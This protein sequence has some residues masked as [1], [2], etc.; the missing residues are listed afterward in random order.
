[1]PSEAVG[2]SGCEVE[3][4]DG[5]ISQVPKP[6]SKVGSGIIGYEMR[7]FGGTAA[8]ASGHWVAMLERVF[9]VELGTRPV[10]GRSRQGVGE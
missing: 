5:E 8:T 4:G 1:M 2:A 7:I 10:R 6:F 3:C 9:E